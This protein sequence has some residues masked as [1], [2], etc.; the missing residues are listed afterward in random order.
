MLIIHVFRDRN[1]TPY[2]HGLRIR[3]HLPAHS[4]FPPSTTGMPAAWLFRTALKANGTTSFGADLPT[5]SSRKGDTY[6]LYYQGSP[7][8]DDTCESV[9]AACHWCGH[10][11]RRGPLGQVS[12]TRSSPGPARGA[13]RKVRSARR[14]GWVQMAGSTFI[15]APIP[16]PVVHKRQRQARGQR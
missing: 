14:H 6:Y 3:Y 2:A 16:A 11:H 4:T 15:T 13:S 5:P 8:Y 10:Q 1:S 7:S 12:R 9:S